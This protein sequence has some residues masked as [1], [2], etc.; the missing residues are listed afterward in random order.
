MPDLLLELFSEEIPARMQARAAEDLQR[1]IG[2]ELTAAGLTFARS[3]AESGPRR[4]MLH[5]EGLSLRSADIREERKG[6]RVGAPE[7]AIEGFLRSAGLNS[8]A[9]CETRDDGKGAFHVAIIDKPGRGAA[10]IVAELVPEVIRKFPWPKSM[11]WGASRLR[12]VR[13]LHAI[14]CVLDGEVVGLPIAGLGEPNANNHTT[15]VAH[16]H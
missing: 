10:E 6:P 12:W 4:L 14:L 5:I 16:F 1:L 2:E 13:P 7:K 11:R 9:D 8:L 15:P 3:E